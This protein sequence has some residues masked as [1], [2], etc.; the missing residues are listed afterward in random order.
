[1]FKVLVINPG[2]TSTKIAVFED[3]KSIFLKTIRHP[4]EKMDQFDTIADQYEF[5]KE[6]ILDELKDAEIDISELKAVVGR[7]GMVRPIESGVY[8]VND[9][10]KRDLRKGVMGQHASNLGGLIADDVA[11]SIPGARAFIADPVVVDELEDVARIT[12][13]PLMPRQSKFH[14]L[15]QKAVARKF[16]EAI[17]KP[18]EEINLIVAHLGG[19]ISVGAHRKG[20]IVDVNNALDG[21]GPFSPERAGTVPAGKLVDICFSG[22]Y[23]REEVRAM[24]TGKG[25]LVAHLGTNQAHVATQWAEEGN[26]KARLVIHAMGY[27][28]ARAIGSALVVLKGEVDGIILTGGMAHNKMVVKYIREYIDFL[29]KITIYPGEDEMEALAMNALGVLKGD[30]VCK[31]YE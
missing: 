16:A 9:A 10:L 30:L 31:D 17:E 8:E 13:H 3:V 26:E 7:G 18:Y 21:F 5:R 29:G 4:S 19:G 15:N 22:D 20:K 11:K 27:Q 12:G 25:G 6:V 23:S 14:A 24:I 2:S 28:V 1:M